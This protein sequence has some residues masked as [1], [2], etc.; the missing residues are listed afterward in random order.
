MCG[1]IR[2]RRGVR[3]NHRRADTATRDILVGDFFRR[4]PGHRDAAPSQPNP[5]Q[6]S[7][8]SQSLPQTDALDDSPLP[9]S[10]IGDIATTERDA[11]LLI[12]IRRVS[13]MAIPRSIVSR[14]ATACAESLEGAL[15]GHQSWAILCRYC[16]HPT[17]TQ[18]KQRL[19][20]WEAGD[21]HDL[22]GRILSR[23]AA[24]WATKEGKE[25]H[26][27]ADRGTALEKSLHPHGQRF[28]QQS[29][30]R[31]RGW[32][33]YGCSRM[34]DALDHSL[35]SPELWPRYTSL[36]R[37]ASSSD[38]AARQIQISPQRCKGTRTQQYS[39]RITLPCQTGTHECRRKRQEYLD[40]IIAFA[41][42]GQKKRL[43]RILDI[44]AVK[45]AA[46]DVPE[47]C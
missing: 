32:S 28:D 10:P 19:Q 37:G 41:G 39:N 30:E 31:A 7:A 44:L 45:C 14:F 6:P 4:Q 16:C 40:A 18:L 24:H 13:P 38:S 47:E 26:A 17:E 9:N 43:S 1:T 42:A 29:H 25:N 35:D 5:H 33:G 21:V 3:C 23:T 34:S 46:G 2:L 20:L 22:I 8:I 36:E 11:Q 27:A 12:D 15:T